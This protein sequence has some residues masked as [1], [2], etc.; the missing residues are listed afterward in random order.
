MEHNLRYEKKMIFDALRLGEVRSWVYSHSNAF[1]V[2]YPPRQ[3]NNLYFDT[4]ERLLMT[5]HA[6]G[7][8]NRE[9]F[10]FR[11]YGENWC[12]REGNIEIKKKIGHLGYKITH[13]INNIIDFSRLDWREIIRLLKEKSSGDFSF[14]LDNLKP[15]VI[16]QYQRE[17]FVSADEKI[18]V[19]LDYDMKAFGQSFGFSPN[20]TFR[21]LLVN[22][23]IIEMKA[24]MD[25]CQRIADALAEF[26]LRCVQNSKYLN[27]MEYVV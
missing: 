5:E 24:T 9:K 13:P 20:I 22:N 15:V 12:A 18:R 7:V 11:W 4:P 10:R 3:V 25:E 1:K 21:Q 14:L 27:A 6:N 17:Y 19:T 23:V 16:N 8:A 2:A 26:P